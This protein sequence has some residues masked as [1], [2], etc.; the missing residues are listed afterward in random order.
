[1]KIADRLR[2]LA[3]N[4]KRYIE[5]NAT[6]Y[7]AFLQTT[8]PTADYD[9]TQIP[10]FQIRQLVFLYQLANLLAHAFHPIGQDKPNDPI[11][12]C[13]ILVSKLPN[14]AQGFNALGLTKSHLDQL[15]IAGIESFHSPELAENYASDFI[16]MVREA[17]KAFVQFPEGEGAL[18]ATLRGLVHAIIPLKSEHFSAFASIAYQDSKASPQPIL[19]AK[20]TIANAAPLAHDDVLAL[21]LAKQREFWDLHAIMQPLMGPKDNEEIKLLASNR[22][23]AFQLFVITCKLYKQLDKSKLTEDQLFDEVQPIILDQ[24]SQYGFSKETFEAMLN[25]TELKAIEFDDSGSIPHLDPNTQSPIFSDVVLRFAEELLADI[26]TLGKDATVLNELAD[27][28]LSSTKI[29]LGMSA[30]LATMSTDEIAVLHQEFGANHSDKEVLVRNF[31][32]TNLS[33]LSDAEAALPQLLK[34]IRE[35]NQSIILQLQKLYKAMLENPDTAECLQKFADIKAAQSVIVD[36]TTNLVQQ[37]VELERRIQAYH[38]AVGKFNEIIR[39]LERCKSQTHTV[40]K[41]DQAGNLLADEQKDVVVA[42]TQTN[43]IQKYRRDTVTGTMIPL[44][45]TD[46]ENMQPADFSALKMDIYFITEKTR[47]IIHYDITETARAFYQLQINGLANFAQ[48]NSQWLAEQTKALKQVKLAVLKCRLSEEYKADES[49][50]VAK[51][52]SFQ[53]ES[54]DPL[55]QQIRQISEFLHACSSLLTTYEAKVEQLRQTKINPPEDLKGGTYNRT[56]DEIIEQYNRLREK[57]Q[58]EKVRLTFLEHTLQTQLATGNLTAL[59]EQQ[60]NLQQKLADKSQLINALAQPISDKEAEIAATRTA[61]TKATEQEDKATSALTEMESKLPSKTLSGYKEES[62]KCKLFWQGLIS[63]F[64]T[65]PISTITKAQLLTLMTQDHFL[66]YTPKAVNNWQE[67][68][69]HGQIKEPCIEFLTSIVEYA[70]IQT[71]QSIFYVAVSPDD[72]KALNTRIQDIDKIKAGYQQVFT[73]RSSVNASLAEKLP[74]F[75]QNLNQI[76]SGNSRYFSTQLIEREELS[77]EIK[78]A[79]LTKQQLSQQLDKQ[80]QELS[81][82]QQKAST[83]QRER[84]QLQHQADELADKIQ[85]INV[86]RAKFAKL[87]QITVGYASILADYQF[88]LTKIREIRDHKENDKYVRNYAFFHQ[89]IGPKLTAE[90]EQF[91]ELQQQQLLQS[92]DTYREQIRF[93]AEE[94]VILREYKLDLQDMDQQIETHRSAINQINTSCESELKAAKQYRDEEVLKLDNLLKQDIT[95]KYG[96]NLCDA[97]LNIFMN[98][99]IAFDT[100]FALRTKK[101]HIKDRFFKSDAFN[102]HFFYNELN[103]LLMTY[104]YTLTPESLTALNSKIE[105]GIIK[106]SPRTKNTKSVDYKE[107]MK[108]CLETLQLQLTEFTNQHYTKEIADP[109]LQEQLSATKVAAASS[110]LVAACAA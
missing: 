28:A 87:E 57:L 101:Y 89:I 71:K 29:S 4:I 74:D 3:D 55:D 56:Y 10:N 85:K 11:D 95:A 58:N 40:L 49:E 110:P 2:K 77:T 23:K 43:I 72:Q 5:R 81:E 50:A 66:S 80:V 14:I 98:A 90:I 105:D 33:F 65:N 109:Y 12:L 108:S 9:L 79:G 31:L 38:A 61:L 102:R 16:A 107:T 24:F 73:S 20:R 82:L 64:L 8:D 44:S 30:L 62:I 25:A 76:V 83:L 69:Q 103:A 97:R 6:K 68:L 1:M 106:F 92:H 75:F 78:E 99:K 104:L 60:D 27:A 88:R 84:Q 42:T 53:N 21:Y 100:Y 46:E 94:Q 59:Q 70:F 54:K 96:S 52:A 17:D 91:D 48:Q 26:T 34:S 39:I 22:K 7:N 15:R 63:F 93:T 51:I 86:T 41:L 67:V 18:S 37:Q 36:A 19:T 45:S 47:Y 13:K 32:K 35:G